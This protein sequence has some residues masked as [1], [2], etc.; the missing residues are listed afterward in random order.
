[1]KDD[2]IITM[3]TV[4]LYRRE[5]DMKSK[6]IIA[7]LLVITLGLSQF[8]VALADKKTEA[9]NTKKQAEENLKSKQS[10]INNIEQ[11]QEQI[12]KEINA[13]DAELVEV[14]IKLSTL[15]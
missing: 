12:K 1:M 11:E 2:V 4:N 13:L 9:E 15:E 7:V 3:D 10:E 14:I 8:S 5:K 6:K